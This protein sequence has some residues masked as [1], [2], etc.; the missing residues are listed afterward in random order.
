MSSVRLSE[1]KEV[2]ICPMS[3]VQRTSESAVLIGHQ[4]KIVGSD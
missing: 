1:R 2:L 3:L 4:H